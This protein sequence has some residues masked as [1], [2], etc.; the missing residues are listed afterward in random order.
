MYRFGSLF[1][2]IFADTLSVVLATPLVKISNPRFKMIPK[3]R[4][5]KGSIQW[6]ISQ[7]QSVFSYLGA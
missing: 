4:G 2:L 1:Y 5:E 6:L 3:N 7:S